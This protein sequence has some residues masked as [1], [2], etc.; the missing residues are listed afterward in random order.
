M[1]RKVCSLLLISSL[2]LSATGCSFGTRKEIAGAIQSY[3]DGVI[4]GDINGIAD[5]LKDDSKFTEEIETYIRCYTFDEDL[6]DVYDEVL[7]SMTYKIDKGSIRIKDDKATADITYTLTD[8][9]DIY[10]DTGDDADIDEYLEALEEGR[11]NT[12]DIRQTVELEL[13]DD[14]WKI[15]DKN[16]EDILETY[17]F[18]REIFECGLLE[19]P[20]V[21]LEGFGDAIG[22]ELD[23]TLQSYNYCDGE[24]F[25]NVYYYGDDIYV[26]LYVYTHP[27]QAVTTFGA[28]YDLYSQ[29]ID[30][31]DFEGTSVG[32][33]N[34]T[35][36]LILLNGDSYSPDLYSDSYVY[37]TVCLR[38]DTYIIVI[39]SEDS[40][41]SREKVDLLLE[42]VGLPTPV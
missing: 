31:E 39:T 23:V 25:S 42:A 20:A 10:R 29:M 19:L 16:N 26:D 13:T 40:D 41:S 9:R 32:F 2:L 7:S 4:E 28:R 33:F 30:E 22:S 38:N 12:R 35:E 18:Y 24:E 5:T 8:Y 3:A 34:D 6:N 11:D 36:G 17:E 15:V 27:D 21:S 14:G 37:G 1:K